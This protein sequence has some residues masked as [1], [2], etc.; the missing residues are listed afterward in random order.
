MVVVYALLRTHPHE[1][2][3]LLPNLNP[4][5]YDVHHRGN[6]NGVDLN[7][8]FPNGRQ[9]ETRV[10]VALIKRIHPDVTIWFHQAENRVRGWGGSETVAR[11]YARRRDG[12]LSI[13]VR[14]RLAF[15]AAELELASRALPTPVHERHRGRAAP[16]HL[17]LGHEFEA[18][19]HCGRASGR[20][21][22]GYHC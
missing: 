5:G 13:A 18:T 17:Y 2:L 8:T 19:A 4:D 16:A 7:R 14:L 20:A 12:R 3:W 15:A 9:P 11:R 6:A 21:R 1:D 22:P 10:A